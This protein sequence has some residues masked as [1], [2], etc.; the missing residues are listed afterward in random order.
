[1]RYRH[2]RGGLEESL[3]MTVEV[4]SLEEMYAHLNK[5]WKEWGKFVTEIKFA[6]VG[7]DHRTGWDTYYVMQRLWGETDFT[8]AGMSDGYF[9][10]HKNVRAMK[11]VIE[12]K[13][14]DLDIDLSTKIYVTKD[15]DIFRKKEGNRDIKPPLVNKLYRSIMD[16]GYLDVSILIVGD[17]MTMLDGQHRIEA[18]KRIKQDT[19]ATYKVKYMVSRSFDD[20]QKIIA[21]QKDRSSWTTM[22]Y[23]Q[24]YAEMG[25]PHYK[26]YLE[27]RKKYKIKHTIASILL[28]GTVSGGWNSE[29][30]R[31]GRFMVDEYSRSEEWALRLQ[32]LSEYYDFSHNRNFVKAL[33]RYWKHPEFS[34]RE[35]MAKV[36]KFRNKLYNCVSVPEF[37]DL[38]GELYNYHRQK[39]I[40]FTFFSD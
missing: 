21:W 15:Y 18:L 9:N 32:S 23:A 6:H 38:I 1:M 11:E 37:S 13:K 34:H 17:H 30:F 8:V 22:D 39:R 10:K 40:L 24:S 27:F 28:I 26:T 7:M 2:H 14:R 3:E 33:I 12:V 29:H 31:Q 20:L 25:N 36:D 16:L 4:N 19:G 35:F 5:V